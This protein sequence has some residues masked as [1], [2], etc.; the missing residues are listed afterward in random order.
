MSRRSRGCSIPLMPCR[1]HADDI[2]MV[3]AGRRYTSGS[4]IL[5]P[6]PQPDF[7]LL[8]PRTA[9]S[10]CK[11]TDRLIGT[12]AGDQ[13]ERRRPR[14]RRPSVP[15]DRP[16]EDPHQNPRSPRRRHWGVSG[17]LEFRILCV[18][19]D[20]DGERCVSDTT[21][22][23]TLNLGVVMELLLTTLRSRSNTNTG[24]T[25]ITQTAQ[26]NPAQLLY[27][28]LSFGFSLAVNA[29]IFFRI[30]GGLFNPAVSFR[31]DFGHLT[32]FK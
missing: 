5:I 25:V 32:S 4:K 13:N 30:S 2:M 9:S 11:T 28:S 23:N 15:S 6:V 12:V 22:F 10:S 3:P 24:S 16:Q 29:W 27:I 7:I 14:W 31:S 18:C 26:K 8:H 17:H 19:G 1:E 21:S 20:A